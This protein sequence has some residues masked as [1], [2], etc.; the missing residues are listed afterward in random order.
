MESDPHLGWLVDVG[1]FGGGVNVAAWLRFV[2]LLGA[3]AGFE[4]EHPS[5]GIYAD[6][7]APPPKA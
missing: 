5:L 1:A 4:V 2:W 7:H 6:A 3:L